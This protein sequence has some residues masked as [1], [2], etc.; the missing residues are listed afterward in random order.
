MKLNLQ[1]NDF[2]FCPEVTTKI[3][4]LNEVIKEV[5]ISF[6][7]RTVAEGKKIQVYD[8]IRALTTILKYKYFV[9]F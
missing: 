7:G 6:K 5:P 2:A 3:S 9:K 8:A 1:E 4:L